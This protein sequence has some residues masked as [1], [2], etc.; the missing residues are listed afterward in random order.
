MLDTTTRLVVLDK[1]ATFMNDA[2]RFPPWYAFEAIT[3]PSTTALLAWT[4]DPTFMTDVTFALDAKR[5]P[6]G[7]ETDPIL[8]PPTIFD[9]K[10]EY[11]PRAIKF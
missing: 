7:T 5:F 10:Y 3:F 8:C 1:A 11:A 4:D 6:K 2:K 9:T